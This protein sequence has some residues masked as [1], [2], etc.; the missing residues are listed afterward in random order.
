MTAAADRAEDLYEVEPDRP[1]LSGRR[2]ALILAGLAVMTAV[3]SW[4]SWNL[5]DEPVRWQDV[6][7]TIDSG[8][9]TTVTFDVFLYTDEPVVCHVRALNVA[10]AEVGVATIAV[11]TTAGAEQRFTL[12]V[13]T[14]E[15]AT[16]V[17]V[18]YCITD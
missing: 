9:A 11:D 8:S 5:A 3:A 4:I 7:F 13:A 15:E 12:P 10:Y 14:A 17:G 18:R 16:T 2:W 1:R 6:G